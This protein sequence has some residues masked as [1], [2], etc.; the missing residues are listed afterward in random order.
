MAVLLSTQSRR[1]AVHVRDLIH[2][3]CLRAG[4]PLPSERALAK[5]L[6]MGHVT[7]R[8]GLAALVQEGLIERHIGA[9]TFVTN[10]AERS[11]ERKNRLRN[12]AIAVQS[13]VL[14]LLRMESCLAGARQFFPQRDFRIELLDI[15]SALERKELFRNLRRRGVDGLLYQGFMA[16]DDQAVLRDSGVPMVSLGVGDLPPDFPHVQ[17][18][19]AE[20]YCRLIHEAYRFGH[21]KLASVA[22]RTPLD[23]GVEPEP[24]EQRPLEG[25]Y[26]LACR[27]YGL[28]T[29]MNRVVELDLCEADGRFPIDTSPILRLSPMPTCFLVNDEIMAQAVYRDLT[30]AG[31]NVPNDISLMALIDCLPHSH[32]VPLTAPLAEPDIHERYAIAGGMLRRLMDGEALPHNQVRHVPTIHFKASLAPA[33]TEA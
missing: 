22:W 27:R 11:A 6:K 9:G 21:K 3:Q 25:S 28:L 1:A 8:R 23:E 12:V 24:L 16:E 29:S 7:V 14:H 20:L 17:V 15:T 18:D 10:L 32:P 33:R 5:E 19:Y 13:N 2:R 26:Q 31:Y 30:A 4:D